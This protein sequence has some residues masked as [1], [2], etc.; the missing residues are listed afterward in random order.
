MSKMDL[1]NLIR[2]K[3][4]TLKENGI[5]HYVIIIN[6]IHGGKEYENLDLLL[7]RDAV[8]K[9]LNDAEHIKS[10][11]TYKNYIQSICVALHAL[12]EKK[13]DDEIKFYRK[14]LFDKALEYNEII[15]KHEKTKKQSENWTTMKDLVAISDKLKK[16]ITRKKIN[17]K[18]VRDSFE[19]QLQ[20]DYLISLLYTLL[21]PRRLEYA[22]CLI[23]TTDKGLDE[24]KNY[25]YLKN[26]SKHIF[27]FHD[28]KTAKHYGRSDV[29]CPPRIRTAIQH[30]IRDRFDGPLFY[31]EGNTGMNTNNLS[32]AIKRIFTHDG[33]SPTLNIIRHIVASDNVDVDKDKKLNKLATEMGHSRKEQL[34]Y[35]K[36]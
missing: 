3:R 2:E 16:T 27:I 28:Y 25:I 26:K 18:D 7:D 15:E 17:S 12:D 36:Q 19:I 31:N 6:K 23:T 34:Q 35:A 21:P 33:K 10:K 32:K 20:Q 11:T 22:T 5:K 30:L 13:Y 24:T 29:M 4:P 14:M 8:M 1:A 9:Y